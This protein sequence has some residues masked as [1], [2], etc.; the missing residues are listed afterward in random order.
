MRRIVN[1]LLKEYDNKWFT[2]QLKSKFLFYMHV[3]VLTT[4]VIAAVY[5]VIANLNN[6]L[7]DYSISYKHLLFYIISFV[8]VF[9]SLYVLI[10]G[11]YTLA[12]H[13]ILTIVMA[14]VWIFI[15][16]DETDI[17]SRLDSIVLAVA[18][19]SILPIVVTRKPMVM[20]FY[21]G[22]NISILVFF[23]LLYK[24]DL[25]LPKS[26]FISYMSDNT[27]AIIAVTVISY[28][29]FSINRRALERAEKD[30]E[31]R[32][33][34][35]NSLRESEEAKRALIEAIPDI[36]MQSDMKGNILFANEALEKI[37]GITPDQYNDPNRKAR[38][39]PED[40]EML[41]GEIKQLIGTDKTSTGTIENRFID[42]Q[43]NL[44][45]LS[46]KI[47]K[48]NINGN[49]VL[50]T[51]SRD[52]TA[53]KAI[54]KE[55][56]KYRNRLEQLVDEKSQDLKTL[57]EELQAT[58]E[59]LYDKNDI[60]VSQN[61]ELKTTLKHLKETQAKLVQ[62]E[63]MASLGT[64]TAGVA[65]E[66]NNPL[67][68]ING[69]LNV[70][71]ELQKT[72]LKDCQLTEETTAA[73]NYAVEA[74]KEGLERSMNIVSAL[75]TF[76]F[77]GKSTLVEIDIHP[78]IEN[79]LIF[80]KPKIKD[81]IKIL[82]NFNLSD[83]MKVYPDK[84]HQILL[85]I[86]DNAIFATINQDSYPKKIFIN[87]IANQT[88]AIIQIINTGAGIPEENLNQLFDPFF[89]T[90]EPG[91]GTGLGLFICYT[92]MEEHNGTI[93]VENIDGGV[94]FN[95]EFPV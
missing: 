49:P 28:Q 6:P 8:M 32:R 34:V 12:A 30:I 40:L 87:T 57:N 45:W 58:N 64:L 23:L 29:V 65:H 50:Q 53:K 9:T 25:N 2:L 38:V 70:L 56:E 78:I 46:G 18:V 44:H 36:I 42:N 86:L 62:A 93:S 37:L 69:G 24:T 74:V 89:T 16:T 41:S 19:L 77:Q 13:L 55:L 67:N 61:E 84:M 21:A 35:E 17:V 72:L 81:K 90:K 31:E 88:S 85:N 22:I 68:F 66:I 63:K 52:I 60:I 1:N 20:F 4:I 59:E 26:S 91:L 75:M 10:R 27:V 79:T 80:L 14:L 15:F 48:L 54:E 39:H 5:T 76:S 33:K 95:L 3:V 43:G 71:L 11:F 82:K 51:V 94:C 73:L 92:L 47:S 83:A 7:R